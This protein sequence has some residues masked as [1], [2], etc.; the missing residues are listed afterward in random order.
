[1]LNKETETIQ[2]QLADYCKSNQN[3]EIPGI[4][5][6]R[7]HHYR[8]L[9]Y[10]IIDDAIESAY[11]I[12]RSILSDEQWKEI[13]DAFIT[14][15]KCH[16]PQLFRMPGEII[17]FVKLK[18]FDKKFNIPYLIDTL[19]FEWVEVEIHSMQDVKIPEIK[20][21]N[22]LLNSVLYFS[23]YFQLLN[24]S[25]PIHKLKDVDITDY[26]GEYFILVYREDNGTVQY[27]ELTVLTHYLLS[28]LSTERTSL[29]SLLNPIFEELGNINKDEWHE[30]GVAFLKEMYSI[31]IVK[32]TII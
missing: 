3:E 20:I 4:K 24:L 31:G 10:N 32:G 5:K 21:T 25:Y 1:M 22:D 16:H 15:H 14:D 17:E 27:V 18:Q 13:I 7:L 11:P 26:K 9:I 19:N 6:D 28:K 29:K 12:T 8:R 30:K 23:P 2:H